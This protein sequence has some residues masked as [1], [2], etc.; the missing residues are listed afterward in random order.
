MVDILF[1]GEKEKEYYF[2]PFAKANHLEV[3]VRRIARF[4]IEEAANE[5]LA[6][7]PKELIIDADCI[8][9][10]GLCA[11]KL[12]SIK[13]AIGCKIILIAIGYDAAH[14]A[15][16]KRFIVSGISDFVTAS[17]LGK[18]RAEYEAIHEG[19][20][21]IDP[22]TKNAVT[23][24]AAAKDILAGEDEEPLQKVITIGVCG[25]MERI[26]TTTL[27][28]QL[29]KFMALKGRK[30]AY[31]ERNLTGF[32][33]ATKAAYR[34]EEDDSLCMIRIDGVDMFYDLS[35][36]K[37]IMREGYDCFIYD[38]G[39]CS[40]SNIVSIL[41]QQYIFVCCGLKNKEL[42]KTYEALRR[43]L[44]SEGS[45]FYAFN[46]VHKSLQEQTL[47]MMDKKKNQTMFLGNTPEMFLLESENAQ[48]FETVFSKDEE[49]PVERKRFKW[50]L[51][52]KR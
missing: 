16:L 25:C 52:K 11:A 4:Q 13:E 5:I 36:I 10:E 12:S 48:A 42:T 32:V 41:E 49:N 22:E 14:A 37:R 7:S 15:L 44:H 29:A 39:I 50:N 24:E 38:Y 43:F 45:I 46:F 30:V 2:S 27:A 19:K 18:A 26:G 47:L 1:Y 23:R 8:M 35:Y 6:Q 21:L 9:D 20:E 3:E 33:E 51:K 17:S 28:L 31:L 34:C 40:N